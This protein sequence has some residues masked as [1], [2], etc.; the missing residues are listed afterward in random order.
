[1]EKIMSENQEIQTNE[2]DIDVL[3]AQ[4]K[5]LRKETTKTRFLLNK[6]RKVTYDMNKAQNNI[7][8]IIIAG[9]IVI[10]ILTTISNQISREI[11][12]KDDYIITIEEE[13]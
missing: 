12:Q 5:E 4:L 3:R 6:M 8:K 9:L 13:E 2:E 11:L 10:P 1:M 7:Y